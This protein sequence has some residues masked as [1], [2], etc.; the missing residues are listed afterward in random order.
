M[1]G[2]L[3]GWLVS[4]LAGL[5]GWLVWLVGRLVGWLVGWWLACWLT[6]SSLVS[7]AM[8]RK[9]V[10]LISSFASCTLVRAH[11]CSLWRT[12]MTTASLYLSAPGMTTIT[13]FT[14]HGNS[15]AHVKPPPRPLCTA[16][17]TSVGQVVPSQTLTSTPCPCCRNPPASRQSTN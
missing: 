7:Q 15:A 13:L 12:S 9:C 6:G 10:C 1:I 4:W 14:H 5:V 3:A 16:C 17:P 11:L 2:W 8:S